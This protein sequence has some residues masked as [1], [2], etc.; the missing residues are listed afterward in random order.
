MGPGSICTTR[1]VSGAGMPQITAILACARVTREANILAY[2]DV[3]LVIGILACLLFLWGV[4]I[5]VRMR[6]RG[7]ISPIVLLAQRMAAMA[8]ARPVEGHKS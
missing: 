1:V 4:S 3:F 5:E 2:N 6:R 8:P 7:E